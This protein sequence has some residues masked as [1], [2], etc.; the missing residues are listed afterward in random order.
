[1]EATA[2]P[3]DQIN[4]TITLCKAILH[5]RQ[6]HP[7]LSEFMEACT[8]DLMISITAM[9]NA[10]ATRPLPI[11]NGK[12]NRIAHLT[13]VSAF[14][15]KIK[16]YLEDAV[17]EIGPP[18]T[19]LQRISTPSHISVTDSKEETDH[20]GQDWIEYDAT[21]PK[22]YPLI[23]INKSNEEEVARYIR[24]HNIGDGVHLQG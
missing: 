9:S 20:L 10:D 18:P 13:Y 21:N 22:H 2:P 14:T 3:P 11:T 17:R 23:F 24:Y 8:G 1:M 19:L 16:P 12:Y 7:E 5:Y 6:A 4:G 15:D